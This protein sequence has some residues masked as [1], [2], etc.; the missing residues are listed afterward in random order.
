[1]H[2]HTI[3]KK[4]D[5]I[6]FEAYLF[7]LHYLFTVMEAPLCQEL[8]ITARALQKFR[9]NHDHNTFYTLLFPPSVAKCEFY[10]SRI[11]QII[12]IQF[13]HRIQPENKLKLKATFISFI[14]YF[15]PLLP[16]LNRVMRREI[17]LCPPPTPWRTI[18]NTV[19]VRTLQ[20]Q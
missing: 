1:M 17:R 4:I 10:G 20:Q 9:P 6:C 5:F 3:V 2:G 18:A 7:L 16:C 8:F 11:T 15:L 19:T 12:I 13:H 14:H